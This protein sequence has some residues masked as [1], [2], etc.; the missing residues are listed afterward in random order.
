MPLL[1]ECCLYRHHGQ[2]KPSSSNAERLSIGS[3]AAA[4][5]DDSAIEAC[6]DNLLAEAVLLEPQVTAMLHELC[7]AFGGELSGLEFKLK[8]RESLLRKMHAKLSEA[9]T[10]AID[11]EDETEVD[12]AALMYGPRITDVLRYTVIIDTARYT[13]GVEAAMARFEGDRSTKT[14]DL[15]NYWSG[16]D[17]YQGINDVFA[18]TAPALPSG[19]LNFEVQFHTPESFASKMDA[20]A[21]YDQ[22]RRTRDPDAKRAL[23]ARMAEL[24]AAVPVPTGVLGIPYVKSRSMPGQA[25]AYAELAQARAVL[26]EPKLCELVRAACAEAGVAAPS[27]T[28]SVCSAEALERLLEQRADDYEVDDAEDLKQALGFMYAGL[29]VS[30]VLPAERFAALAPRVCANL[31]AQVVC[32]STINGW[33][34]AA[35][36]E[37][38]RLS[39]GRLRSSAGDP[40]VEAE[41]SCVLEASI[42]RQRKTQASTIRQRKTQGAKAWHAHGVG[43]GLQIC[44]SAP[45]VDDGVAFTDDQLV[46]CTIM[47]HTAA[48]QAV[49]AE[50]QALYAAYR[51][52]PT[53]DMRRALGAKY[54]ML[55][56]SVAVPEG[57][58]QLHLDIQTYSEC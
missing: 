56:G 32:R 49:Q 19:Y 57:A 31:A 28:S 21:L 52:A 16:N 14:I 54:S 24:A 18:V 36:H 11:A 40:A 20:H 46:P 15:K 27:V 50:L 37:E 34:T 22:F 17:T 43:L 41:D 47:L 26:L 25:A 13:P 29:V 55:V 5:E 10:E 48:S 44:A 35:S 42:L 38:H 51:H 30:L 12:I 3:G 53:R 39:A 8:S 6:A 58:A 9:R 45:G 2:V 7:S 1:F 33:A 4:S 23:W